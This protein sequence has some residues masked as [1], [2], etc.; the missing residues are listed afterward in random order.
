MGE[1]FDGDTRRRSVLR[2]V[3]FSGPSTRL[4]GLPMW[5]LA[6][7]CIS[8]IRR[9]VGHVARNGFDDLPHDDSSR[10]SLAGQLAQHADDRSFRQLDLEIVVSEAPC[11]GEFGFRRPAVASRWSLSRPR[12]PAPL[13]TRRHGLCA[14]PPSASRTCVITPRSVSHRGRDADQRERIAGS[15]THL[16]IQRVLREVERRNL[17]PT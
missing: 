11:A 5:P 15:I 6:S 13:R 12:A 7:V 9:A 16:S 17:A 10:T 3:T 8:G 14:T 2:P 1:P 4:S